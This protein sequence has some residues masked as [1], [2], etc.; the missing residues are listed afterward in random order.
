[1]TPLDDS[2][3]RTRAEAAAQRV[4]AAEIRQRAL[5]WWPCFR[6]ILRADADALDMGAAELERQADHWQQLSDDINRRNF[7]PRNFEGISH[8]E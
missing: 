2:I 8:A 6:G 1:M 3:A 5:W 7:R 4:K